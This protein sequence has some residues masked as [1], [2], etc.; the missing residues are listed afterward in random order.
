MT[1]CRPGSPCWKTEGDLSALETLASVMDTF[2]AH[3]NISR[4]NG[5]A[6]QAS[7]TAPTW[8]TLVT[9]ANGA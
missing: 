7:L 8:L 4:P 5:G 1:G 3:F 9:L 2:D 6:D